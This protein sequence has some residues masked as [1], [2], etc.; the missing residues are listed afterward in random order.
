MFYA[1]TDLQHFINIGW[2]LKSLVE[3]TTEMVR[4]T[5]LLSTFQAIMDL[6]CQYLKC[7]R[8]LL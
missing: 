1:I 3:V 5:S 7:D 2:R 6:S 4:N 8:V